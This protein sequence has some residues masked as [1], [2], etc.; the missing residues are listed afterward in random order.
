MI[1][2]CLVGAVTSVAVL[3]WM[4]HRIIFMKYPSYVKFKDYLKRRN[5]LWLIIIEKLII[6]SLIAGLIFG[7]PALINLLVN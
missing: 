1:I 6:L 7:L 2:Y 3:Y 4:H 5:I